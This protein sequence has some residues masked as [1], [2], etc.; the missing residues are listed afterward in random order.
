MLIGFERK[1]DCMG[2]Y[3]IKQQIIIKSFQDRSKVAKDI[4]Y[5]YLKYIGPVKSQIKVYL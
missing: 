4:R 5:V 1:A 2:L 3:G